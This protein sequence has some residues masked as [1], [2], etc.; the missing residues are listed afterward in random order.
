N[1]TRTSSTFASATQNRFLLDGLKWLGGADATPPPGDSVSET[2]LYSLTN[3][4]NGPWVDARSAAKAPSSA[5]PCNAL[6]PY[7]GTYD[8][9]NLDIVKEAN[10][11]FPK[12]AAA[13]GFNYTA[14]KNWDLVSNGVVNSY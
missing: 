7:P 14:S 3:G 13:N 2:A 5:T 11:W 1:N 10:D 9:A 6:P 12:Q 8:A 4:G